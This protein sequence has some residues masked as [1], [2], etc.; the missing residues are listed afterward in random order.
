MRIK[1]ITVEGN[2]TDTTGKKIETFKIISEVFNS[3]VYFLST[4]PDRTVAIPGGTFTGSAIVP[5]ARC[6][7]IKK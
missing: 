1:F 5:A 4:K 2:G 7:C 6:T 3:T